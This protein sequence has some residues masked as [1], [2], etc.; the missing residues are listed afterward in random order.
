MV[1]HA[2]RPLTL[3][4]ALLAA[5]CLALS[6]AGASASLTAKK[7]TSL[8]DDLI[9][10][11]QEFNTH[12]QWR[13]Y[14]YASNFVDPELKEDFAVALDKV[15]DRIKIEE[16]QIVQS[17]L[18]PVTETKQPEG[19]DPKHPTREARVVVKLINANF[20]PSNMVVTRRFVEE[21]VYKNGTWYIRFVPTD[22]LG[23]TPKP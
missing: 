4:I 7:E 3:V 8:L 17:R 1:P 13:D 9:E 21:W 6:C 22:L 11:S 15:E 14:E 20:A 5:G 12:L 16:I 18:V 2:H 23:E 10:T 19:T